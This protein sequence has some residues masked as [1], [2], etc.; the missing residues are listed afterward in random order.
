MALGLTCARSEEIERRQIF[1]G[2]TEVRINDLNKSATYKIVQSTSVIIASRGDDI[3][4]LFDVT[5]K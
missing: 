5:F 1:A 3:R 4:C 2:G